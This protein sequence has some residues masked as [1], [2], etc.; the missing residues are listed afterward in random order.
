MEH[1][2]CDRDLLDWCTCG[3]VIRWPRYGQQIY[4]CLSRIDRICF[5]AGL[6]S[7]KARNVLHSTVFHCDRSLGGVFKMIW[8]SHR[9]IREF[10]PYGVPMHLWIGFDWG[11]TTTVSTLSRAILGTRIRSKRIGPWTH[12]RDDESSSSIQPSLHVRARAFRES[13]SEANSIKMRE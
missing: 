9:K 12:W 6:N 11:Q 10:R 2:L 1:C 3:E 8:A 13:E 7:R 4:R 5:S